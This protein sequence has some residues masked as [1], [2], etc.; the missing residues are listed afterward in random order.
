VIT[1][2]TDLEAQANETGVAD[3]RHRPYLRL[4]RKAAVA[5]GGVILI[6][7][8]IAMLVLPGPGVLAILG[9]LGLL[10]TEFPAARRLSDRLNGYV[11]TA[12][13]KVR[14]NKRAE[15]VSEKGEDGN[16]ADYRP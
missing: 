2:A 13:N 16:D 6:I 7:A 1:T 15:R 8:G 12:W 11:R 5:V 14:P 9:G 10:G 4:L 3:G